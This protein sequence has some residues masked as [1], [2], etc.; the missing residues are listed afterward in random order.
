MR[1]YKGGLNIGNLYF[2]QSQTIKYVMND[3]YYWL[4][5]LFTV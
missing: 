1:A 2:L 4:P 3:L 5:F